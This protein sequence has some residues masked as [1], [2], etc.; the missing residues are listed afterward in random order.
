[1][2]INPIKKDF[3]KLCFM[4][5]QTLSNFPFLEQDFDSLTNYGFLNK[6]IEYLNTVINTTNDVTEETMSLYNAFIELRD[7]INNYFD[8]LD[9][10][11]EIN[12]KLDEMTE[13][14]TLQELILEYLNVVFYFNNVDAMKA[15]NHL[16][17]GMCVQTLG[18]YTA[19]DGGASI[20]K[21]RTKT[22][23]DIE[24][25]GI[26]HFIGTSLVAELI[27][28]E[29]IYVEQFGA[30]GDGIQNDTPF[31]QKCFDSV[32]SGMTVNFSCD[33][34][35]LVKSRINIPYYINVKGNNAHLY[36]NHDNE[37]FSNNDYMLYYGHQRAKLKN[38][39][40]G[41]LRSCIIQDLCFNH[42]G[43]TT[44]Q[45]NC[46]FI[47]K[48]VEI[49]NIYSW[50]FNKTIDIT[51]NYIDKVKIYGIE[52]WGKTGSD[53]AINTGYAGDAREVKNVHLYESVGDKKTL[54]TGIAHKNIVIDT[55][56]NGDIYIDGSYATIKNTHLEVGQITIKDANVNLD[57]I[58]MWK[59]EYYPINILGLSRVKID[60]LNISYVV[61]RI[62]Y[63]ENDCIDVY[64]ENDK[65]NVNFNNCFKSMKLDADASFRPY[66]GITTNRTEFNENMTNNSIYSCSYGNSVS[67]DLPT[68]TRVGSYNILGSLYTKGNME[69]EIETG[70]YYYNAIMMFDTTRNVGNSTA[71]VER[72]KSLE[73]G[74]N[75]ITI[76]IQG[77]P[78]SNY[79]FY[80][81]TST[82]SYDKYL[83]VG[84]NGTVFSDNGDIGN[85]AVWKD[86][87][88]ENV[89]TVLEAT[90]FEN[91]GQNVLVY[92][93]NIPTSGTWKKG[94]VIINTSS[95][96][97][98]NTYAWV[99]TTAGTPGTW[100]TVSRIE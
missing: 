16:K 10:Q 96:N 88:A 59:R 70:T 40:D 1:M 9:V 15:S 58:Y 18:Y 69:W 33:K 12:N 82:G 14:G 79:R 67:S 62:K 55:I 87:A 100:K 57:S 89:D 71:K 83:D 11:E 34:K 93:S 23:S 47:N 13:S 51:T 53:Y 75:G 3:K 4:K 35:Y 2:N 45:F 60:N 99:C 7:Y 24:D 66:A 73:K 81:G 48:E 38:D 52:I 43:T 29:N 76:Q 97:S 30:K 98:N 54:Y 86:R 42:Y 85:C 21:I 78:F 95:L 6:I 84:V 46:I 61:N 90:Y 68:K 19:N 37:N 36:I 31:I 5:L 44:K 56:I 25:N 32:Y 39:V 26:I 50:G 92:A 28:N 65:S 80:R 49:K 17:D 63:N 41:Y 20:Y 72:S 77:T 22:S 27:F 91:K 94:D 8:N 64:I 74:G